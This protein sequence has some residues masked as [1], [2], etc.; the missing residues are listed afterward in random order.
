[1]RSP[2]LTLPTSLRTTADARALS[3]L[4]QYFG[5]DDPRD[6]F[7]GA[8]FDEWDTTGTRQTDADRL[9]PDDFL[10]LAC[11]SEGFPPRALH[12]VLVDDAAQFNALLAQIPSDV[13]MADLEEPWTSDH[14]AW[15]LHSALLQLPK[16]G[17]TRASKLLARKRP[18]LVPIYDSFVAVEM[19][20]GGH[21][22]EPLRIMLRTTGLHERLRSLK[23]E[24][25]VP[26]TVS[27]LRVLDVIAWKDR[28]DVVKGVGH[29]DSGRWSR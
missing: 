14:P 20:I 21:H 11:L 16:V 6:A 28:W 1:M 25:G 22:W 7:Y 3:Q 23:S 27:P 19:G 10:S 29:A 24:A 2:T 13:D 9:T 5:R 4:R 18:R 8:M 26:E 17:R 12:T 15:R